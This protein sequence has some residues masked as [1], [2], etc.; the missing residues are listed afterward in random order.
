M[1]AEDL[2]KKCFVQSGYKG[3]CFL[4]VPNPSWPSKAMDSVETP[5][6]KGCRAAHRYRGFKDEFLGWKEIMFNQEGSKQKKKK[7][8]ECLLGTWLLY[9]AVPDSDHGRR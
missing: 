5:L 1:V 4:N 6:G 9:T 3:S 8:K 7:K 2:E